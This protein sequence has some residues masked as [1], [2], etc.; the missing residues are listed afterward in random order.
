M[1]VK[2]FSNPSSLNLGTQH[3]T[4]VA[5]FGSADLDVTT[6]NLGTLSFDVLD[7]SNT[8]TIKARGRDR[9][10]VMYSDINGDGIIDVEIHF[11]TDGFSLACIG[12][13]ILVG[14]VTGCSAPLTAIH[15][16]ALDPIKVI[17]AQE[18]CQ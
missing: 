11:V 1:N 2:P 4:S 5:I 9:L 15:D 10:Q 12:Q 7:P 18:S 16:Q 17:N 14:E 13:G 8:A 6:L 3:A